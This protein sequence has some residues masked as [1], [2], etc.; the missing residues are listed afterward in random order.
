MNVKNN[1]NSKENRELF[2]S[3]DT[4]DIYDYLIA[5][6][7]GAVG[8]IVDAFLVGAPGESITGKWTDAQ[9]DNAVKY[10]AKKSGWSPRK[11]KSS[12]VASAIGFLERKYKVNY[13]QR[14]SAD[15]NNLFKMRTKNHHMMSLAHSPDVIGLFFS[16]LNQ[17]TSTSSFVANGQLIFVD[18]RTYELQ[19]ENYIA[20]LFCG[21]AN[22][23]GHVMSDV[24]GSSG[25]RGGVGRGTG[26]VI[27]FYEVFG[28][29][30]FGSFDVGKDR[31][32]LAVIATRAF[33]E[34]YDLRFGLTTAIP[35]VLTD[36]LIRLVW[37]LRRYFQYG[38][39]ISECV[40]SSK[41]P[42][43]RIMLIFGNTTLC[44]VDGL[45]AGIR[46]HGNFLEF[47]MRLNLC[48]WLRLT[49]L[50][51]K[52]IC[53]RLG[54][55]LPMQ[56]YLAAYQKVNEALV[57]Y[58]K[59]LEKLDK[60]K[61][62]EE[63]EKYNNLVSILKNITTDEELNGILKDIYEKLGISKPWQGEFNEHMSNKNGTLVFK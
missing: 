21:V 42:D 23:I 52:E 29:C 41:H 33:Q 11:E 6:A 63:T 40:P 59:E 19:G 7:C 10:F 8:G 45:D 47:F 30:K 20:K 35:V 39:K 26:I 12:N 22:W 49:A 18:T 27:P 24:A 16:L 15:V 5:V 48:A 37:A 25:S 44:V 1:I 17:F 51:L 9:V 3:Y 50:V 14:H 62:Q 2:Q 38:K 43:L 61:F 60:V 58:L 4:C 57:L 28:F 13:D 54:L 31:Q 32:D 53:I 55:S 46:A 56:E 34:G 36:L